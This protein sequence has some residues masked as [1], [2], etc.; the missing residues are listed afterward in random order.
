[1]IASIRCVVPH[2]TMK[3]PNNQ[4]TGRKG[5]STRF[6]LT[7]RPNLELVATV[8]LFVESFYHRTLSDEE[9]SGRLAIATHELLENAVKY[10]V[11]GE[12]SLR[13]EIGPP[14]VP[15]VLNVSTRN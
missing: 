6:E 12:T 7:L 3:A 9:L 2:S 1:M 11:D 5:T 14:S 13:I 8:R 15:R 4:N 10:S